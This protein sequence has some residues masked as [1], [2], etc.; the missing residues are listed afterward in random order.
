MTSTAVPPP[1]PAPFHPCT[2]LPQQTLL[3]ERLAVMTDGHVLRCTHCGKVRGL[4]SKST[5]EWIDRVVMIFGP[6]TAPTKITR[7]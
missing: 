1:L 6:P 7:P 5:A 2:L 4:L 3:R